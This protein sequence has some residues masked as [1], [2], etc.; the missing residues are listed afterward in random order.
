M[1]T[2]LTSLCFL[3]LLLGLGSFAMAAEPAPV[4]ESQIA[5]PD[6]AD[7]DSI[8]GLTLSA[9][10]KKELAA[11][12]AERRQ[13][14]ELRLEELRKMSPEEKARLREE[15]KQDRKNRN[16]EFRKNKR[17]QKEAEKQQKD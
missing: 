13:A 16:Q 11:R 6:G 4:M 14:L 12:R 3:I 7:H 8:K 10:Q 5:T 1:K 15:F 2:G 9:E 17:E